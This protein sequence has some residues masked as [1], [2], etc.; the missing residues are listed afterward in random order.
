MSEGGSLTYAVDL[1]EGFPLNE[2][3][4][5]PIYFRGKHIPEKT[6]L[7]ETPYAYPL[8]HVEKFFDRIAI[9][10]I[11]PKLLK[12]GVAITGKRD[13]EE[14][15]GNLAL[16]L[17]NIIGDPEKKR[18]FSNLLRMYCLLSMISR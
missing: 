7:L 15:A 11:D 16:V 17:K 6:L 13:L 4:L 3:E 10:D 18:K 5:I 12:K 14:D 8:P 1:P 2:Q 9:Y